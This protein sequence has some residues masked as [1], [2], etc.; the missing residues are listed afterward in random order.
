[1]FNKLN[2]QRSRIVNVEDKRDKIFDLCI[3]ENFDLILEKII[4]FL[5]S[6]NETEKNKIDSLKHLQ[7][8]ANF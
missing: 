3:I 2:R 6:S 5:K 7:L 8:I 1:M 4:V